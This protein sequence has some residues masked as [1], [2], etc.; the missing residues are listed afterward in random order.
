MKQI[1]KYALALACIILATTSFTSCDWDNSPEP[2][3][4][5]FVTYTISA[6]NVSFSGPEQLLTDIMAW[7]K[8]NSIIY[9]TKVNYTSGEASEFTTTDA[10]AATKYENEFVPKFKAY[11]NEVKSKLATGA[12]GRDVE[13]RA[14]FYTFANRAQGKQGD[15]KYEHIE[16]I[17]PAP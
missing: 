15:L 11:L 14:S 2:E 1:Y 12:Y 16:F 17:Y 5:M 6:G 7:V 8:A 3:H 9:D 4:P 13:V 10:E